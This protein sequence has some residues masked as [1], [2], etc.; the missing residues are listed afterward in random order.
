MKILIPLIFVVT[1]GVFGCKA[2]NNV[3]RSSETIELII[4]QNKKHQVIHGFGASDAWSCQFVGKYWPED[5][6][7]QI[8]DWL[9]SSQLDNDSNPE[10]I[11]LNMWRFN[12]GGGSAAQG[13]NSGIRD[14]WRRAESFMVGDSQYDWN[15]QSGQRWFLK[16]AQERGVE[17]FIG[18]L[19]SP[20]V[21]LTRNGR[22][23]SSDN[24]R[25][26]LSEENYSA[27]AVYL[28]DVV[29]NIEKNDGVFLNYISPFNEPQWDW[30]DGGQ[31]GTPSQNNEIAA[32]TRIINQEFEKRNIVSQL[33]IPETAHY[34]YLYET[35]DKPG[36]GIQIRAFFDPESDNFVGNLSRVT[37]KIAAH[38]Y[39][40]TWPTEN[41]VETR[42]RVRKTIESNPMPIEFWMTEYCI[43]ENNSEITGPG[44]DLGMDAALY[45]ARVM[46]ADLVFANAQSWQWWLGVSPYD[47]ND[48]LVYIDHDKYDGEIYDSKKLWAMG[49]FSRFVL[50]GM[51]RVQVSR[52]DQLQDEDALES[53]MSTAFVS[54]DGQY[55][56]MVLINYSETSI[57][58]VMTT[59]YA[60]LNTEFKYY[61]TDHRSEN[62]LTRK[63][64]I[65][66]GDVVEM[67]A[68]AMI[69]I[70]NVN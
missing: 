18:F 34:K 9:F 32:I 66:I 36:R 5:K 50:P 44:R 45:M 39:F 37:P 2:N 33:E 43:L 62:N 60:E 69:T 12:I 63:G 24:Q 55:T 67:P 61:L 7:E 64:T 26:N 54:D 3:A 28:A 53:L 25:Y 10:G 42:K 21:F 20:P 29:E 31:E 16:A 51:R 52:G 65:V 14:V 57:P 49:H 27:F 46:F 41:L 56:T 35:N 38:S 17:H 40:T 11:G 1:I 4:N 58:F 22:A 13:R 70:T 15:Q 30:I 19:N 59:E 8:A 23:Y 6:K 47:Y 48:G 68:R